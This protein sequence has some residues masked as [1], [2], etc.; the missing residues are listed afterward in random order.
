MRDEDLDWRCYTFLSRRSGPAT[1]EELA[2]GVGLPAE[3]VDASVSRLEKALIV[4]REGDRVRAMATQ[5]SLLA[6]Q[7]RYTNDLPL[8]LENGVIRVRRPDDA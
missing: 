3:A 2:G 7:L 4:S 1:L 8:V 5:E 6:C